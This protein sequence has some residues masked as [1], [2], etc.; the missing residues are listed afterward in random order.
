M[1]SP[2]DWMIPLVPEE[3]VIVSALAALVVDLAIVRRKTSG[4]SR[5]GGWRGRPA[6]VAWRP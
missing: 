6:W 4:G 3:I 5:G 2:L 1:N